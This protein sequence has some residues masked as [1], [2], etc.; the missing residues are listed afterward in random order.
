MDKEYPPEFYQQIR[1]ASSF[2]NIELYNVYLQ[3][4]YREWD[5]KG[6]IDHSIK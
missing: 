5:E 3:K 2:A 1:H 6:F 4:R